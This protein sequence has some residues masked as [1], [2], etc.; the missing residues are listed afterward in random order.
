MQLEFRTLESKENLHVVLIDIIT[1]EE[2][3]IDKILEENA[4]K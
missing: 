2:L 1:P 4:D 3:D